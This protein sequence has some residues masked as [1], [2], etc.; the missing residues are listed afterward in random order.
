MRTVPA[1]AIVDRLC[2]VRRARDAGATSVSAPAPRG[3]PMQAIGVATVVS[4]LRLR[5]AEFARA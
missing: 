1:R 4:Q 3:M 5:D 2:G